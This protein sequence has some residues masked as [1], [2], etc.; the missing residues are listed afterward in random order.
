MKWSWTGSL[1]G[2]NASAALAVLIAFTGVVYIQDHLGWKF[3]FTVPAIL[4]LLSCFLF[5]LVSPLYDKLKAS[6]GL[7]T[8]FAQVVVVACKNGEFPLFR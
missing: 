5:P 2:T 4:M 7:F 6:K 8:G 1:V 3:G